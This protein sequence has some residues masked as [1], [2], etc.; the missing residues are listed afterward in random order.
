MTYT[1]LVQVEDLAQHLGDADWAVVDCR[2][3]LADPNRGAQDYRAGH[4][5]G[6]VYGHLDHDLSD[7]VQPGHT[8][9]HPLPDPAR[10]AATFGR[11]GIDE[12]VQVV[13]YDAAGGALAAA[14][15]WWLLR[16]LGHDGVAVLDGG[17]QAW[18]AA[19]LPTR[20]GHESRPARSFLA[21]S[22]PE[23]IA[24]AEEVA[25]L[26]ADPQARVFDARGADRFRGE[27]ETIDPVAGHIPGAVSAPY[28]DNL[29]PDG[30]LR[31]PAELRARYLELLDGV[32]AADTAAYCGSGVTAAQTLLALAVAGLPGARLYPGSW[33][34]WLTDP[35][36][37]VATGAT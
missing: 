22:R 16:W 17:W 2:F 29:G 25:R 12:R 10:L 9:R 35:T 23:L 14:R 32:E 34:E 11:W 7:P 1:A 36:R 27:N 31:P 13:A 4:I 26:A 20:A 18:L 15:L 3:V 33:S 8:G 5:A 21:H 19:G 28:L 30:R 6:A 37:P 24:M